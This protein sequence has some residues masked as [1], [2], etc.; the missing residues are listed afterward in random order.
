MPGRWSNLSLWRRAPYGLTIT[1]GGVWFVL[2]SLLI[3]F[4][5][6]DA[7][8][9]LLLII[10]GLCAGA[11]A[12]NA[13]YG[14][15]T[16]FALSVRRLAP[17]TAVAGQVFVV[18][19]TV[20]NRRRWGRARGIHLRDFVDRPRMA[21]PEA[22]IPVLRP[23]ESVTVSVPALSNARGRLALSHLRMS[24]RFPFSLF[25]KWTRSTD[26][27]EVIVFPQVG[28]LRSEIHLSSRRSDASG[29][30]HAGLGHQRGDEEFYGIR[31]YRTGDNPRRIHWRRSARTGQLMV[32]QMSKARSQ[33]IWCAV[34]ARIDVRDRA[35]VGA[36]EDAIGAAATAVCGALEQGA[37]V[38]LICGG[39][40]L[41]RLPPGS[42][43]AYRPRLLRE[44]ALIQACHDEKL[45]DH[46]RRLSW[47]PRWQGPVMLFGAAHDDNLRETSRALHR[48]LGPTTIYVPGT[49]ALDGLLLP[50]PE[51]AAA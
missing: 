25:N 45:A 49:P 13:F 2:G 50:E 44:L 36:L 35:Q 39:E 48:A 12:I 47:L 6:I 9:N 10:F 26:R 23:G 16:L 31:E 32:R 43:R 1:P 5:A 46:F 30:S 41:V 40:R 3:G 28:R 51:T 8:I 15:R 27:G 34:S 42:G 17:E 19:Y 29:A 14:W 24:T 33:Q 38:G 11:L 20:T 7:D 21:D 37:R 4:A 18:R 22:Y